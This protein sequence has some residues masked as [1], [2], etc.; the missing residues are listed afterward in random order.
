MG[1]TLE[2]VKE[3]IDTLREYSIRYEKIL[4]SFK[5]DSVGFRMSPEYDKSYYT[6]VNEVATY[7][8]HKIPKLNYAKKVLLIHEV[9]TQNF[10]GFS[11][12]ESVSNIKQLL[13][14]VINLFSKSDAV[15]LMNKLSMESITSNSDKENII[16]NNKVFIVHG[17]DSSMRLEVE[18]YLVKIGLEPVILQE[19]T[20]GGS[21]TISSKFESNSDVGFA[22]VCLTS[23]DK[24]CLKNEFPQEAKLRARQNVIFEL[25]FFMGKLGK[26]KVV[27][28]FDNSQIEIPSDFDGV[29]YIE[30]DSASGWHIKL[31]NEL[32]SA[33]Y[34]IDLNKLKSKKRS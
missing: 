29:I 24:G 4:N 12:Y 11:N 22:I 8:D 3:L 13:D 23:D 16:L 9:G 20:T 30:F 2:D 27:A 10:Y 17:R 19:E 28:L 14:V 21:Q 25:G 32:E 18:K 15:E 1:K 33:G 6:L 7:L 5:K 34:T 31:T 26:E